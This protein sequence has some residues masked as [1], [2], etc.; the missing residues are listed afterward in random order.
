VATVGEIEL[1]PGLINVVPGRARLSLDTR[2]VAEG[3]YGAVAARVEAFARD[4]A[5]RRGLRAT[6]RER[7]RAPV[8][9]MDDAIVDA[10]DAAAATA[11]EPYTRMPSGAAHDTMCVADFVPTAMVFVPCRDGVSHAPEEDADPADAA[12]GAEVILNAVA[13]LLAR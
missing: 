1:E 13:A 12:V 9:P 7:Q 3:A 4:V 8:T 2:G 5:H 11:G 6:F 10:L